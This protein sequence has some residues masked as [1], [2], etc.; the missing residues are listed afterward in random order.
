MTTVE[1]QVKLTRERARLPMY[2]HEGDAAA[3]LYAAGESIIPATGLV[4]GVPTGIAIELPAGYFATVRPRSGLS[5]KGIHVALGT[6]DEGYRGEIWVMMF[7]TSSD[8]YH[9]AMGDRVAQMVIEERHHAIFHVVEELSPS[10]RN[11]M[12]LGSSGK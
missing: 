10:Q 3:D 7:N 9:V 12:G 6:V 4:V 2:R 11:V 1:I 5:M 8:E